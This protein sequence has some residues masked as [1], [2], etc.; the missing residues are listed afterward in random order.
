MAA[1]LPTA[2]DAVDDWHAN[3]ILEAQGVAEWII[4]D[5]TTVLLGGSAAGETTCAT[6]GNIHMFANEIFHGILH[7]VAPACSPTNFTKVEDESG[8]YWLQIAN[9]RE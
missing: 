1:W 3:P 2:N 4:G 5:P 9:R 6:G 7:F 8:G